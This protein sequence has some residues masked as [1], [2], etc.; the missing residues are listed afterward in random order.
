MSREKPLPTTEAVRD[1]RVAI[2]LERKE[3]EMRLG[4][5][6]WWR[7]EKRSDLRDRLTYLDGLSDGLRLAGGRREK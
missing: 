2:D 7:W 5:T 6:P 1:R 3:L 4:L